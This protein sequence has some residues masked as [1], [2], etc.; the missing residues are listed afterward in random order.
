ML[1]VVEDVLS[2]GES[3]LYGLVIFAMVVAVLLF[4]TGFC[5]ALSFVIKKA[6]DVKALSDLTKKDKEDKQ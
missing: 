5:Y 2:F 6:E 4:L 3:T 1:S